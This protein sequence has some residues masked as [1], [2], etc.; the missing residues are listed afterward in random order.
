MAA[1]HKRL[2]VIVE[3]I[4]VGTPVDAVD[5][6][7]GR[8]AL[9]TGR[10][11][12]TRRRPSLACLRRRPEIARRRKQSRRTHWCRHNHAVTGYSPAHEEVEAILIEAQ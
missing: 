12:Q 7:Y 6:T 4:A 1:D 3:L 11:R 10:E 8:Q 9:R 2:S 5:A